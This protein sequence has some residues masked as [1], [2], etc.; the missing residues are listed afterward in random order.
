[1]TNHYDNRS[2]QYS[3]RLQKTKLGWLPVEWEVNELANISTIQ[4]GI[5]KGRKIKP[6]TKTSLVPYMRVANVQDGYLDLEVVK[7]IEVLRTKYPSI[8]FAREIYYS[9][10]EAML[11][12]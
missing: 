6:G 12:N 8:F 1:M 2:F 4:K 9:Q 11:T 5:A 3:T 7:E 10:K